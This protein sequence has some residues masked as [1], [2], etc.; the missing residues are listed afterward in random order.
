M[1][2]HNVAVLGSPD[3]FCR[4]VVSLTRGQYSL[5]L[6]LETG[7]AALE[8]FDI[9]AGFSASVTPIVLARMGDLAGNMACHVSNT[10]YMRRLLLATAAGA[11]TPVTLTV[12]AVE[13]PESFV[14]WDVV[15]G[16]TASQL[17]A[18][19][20]VQDVS[21]TRTPVVGTPEWTGLDESVAGYPAQGCV[22]W[23]DANL[24]F[25]AGFRRRVAV[26][27]LTSS[28][29]KPTGATV[30]VATYSLSSASTL[31]LT[32]TN[33]VM[34]VTDIVLGGLD[35]LAFIMTDT[36]VG[37]GIPSAFQ[38]FSTTIRSV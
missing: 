29:Y 33:Y 17:R 6:T 1:D 5:A 28:G 11:K 9:P 38:P 2:R 36:T 20:S 26:P 31:T 24:V 15:T 16:V 7:P 35:A 18:G 34:P 25:P 21:Y 10:G 14:T 37:D 12:S 3:T 8:C 13:A 23:A 19:G 22:V 32:T 30:V 27:P 4:W